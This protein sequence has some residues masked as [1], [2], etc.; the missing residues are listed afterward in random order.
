MVAAASVPSPA[1]TQGA[2]PASAG[3][4][5]YQETGVRVTA[6]GSCDR[7]WW[8]ALMLY[9]DERMEDVRTL[10][11][12]N[13]EKGG[14]SS[15]LL[16]LALARLDNNEA[17]FEDLAVQYAVD[18]DQ[19]P[20]VWVVDKNAKKEVPGRAP[21]TVPV[22]ALTADDILEV[23]IKMESPF[24]IVL[25]L[26]GIA[27]V[28]TM[29][30]D[31]FNESLMARQE[32]NEE[33]TLAN[34][35]RIMEKLSSQLRSTGANSQPGVWNCVFNLMLLTGN[36]EAFERLAQDYTAKTEKVVQWRDLKAAATTEEDKA[37]Q[38]LGVPTGERLSQVNAAF[39]KTVLAHP[40]TKAAREAKEV[41]GIDFLATR[42]W[43]LSDAS[44]V[45]AFLREAQ[46]EKLMVR[47]V[48][49]NELLEALFRATGVHKH[50]EIFT[51]GSIT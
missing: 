40:Q 1:G 47:L 14:R 4:A 13:M 20:P 27:K 34:A 44:G 9:G 5:E 3:A 45:V 23:T 36:K 15:L 51:P 48:N 7:L 42:F 24:P 6:V 12:T 17:A 32:R 33:T 43:S 8:D 29:G 38:I 16:A 22:R 28:D 35:E 18:T 31:L 10:S 39:M 26:G 25:D 11:R 37:P 50:V 41:L 21:V 49:V 30:I 19:S 2:A 46:R